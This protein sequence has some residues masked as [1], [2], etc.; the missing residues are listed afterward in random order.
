MKP[1]TFLGSRLATGALVVATLA[2]SGCSDNACKKGASPTGGLCLP[3][4]PDVAC[5]D[6]VCTRYVWPDGSWNKS[7]QC[8]TYK[9]CAADC[10]NADYNLAEALYFLMV[11]I[12]GTNILPNPANNASG[13]GSCK[14]SGQVAVN[15]SNGCY[16]STG[17]CIEDLNYSFT[18]C[19][20]TLG[21][22]KAHLTLSSGSLHRVG[23]Y[24]K[25]STTRGYQITG[26]I[27]YSGTLSVG[28]NVL[29]ATDETLT[30]A[31]NCAVDVTMMT[32]STWAITG[33]L[34][35]RAINTPI[36]APQ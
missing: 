6:H 29:E 31:T 25:T 9:T 33:T 21:L 3:T 26:T 19:V 22:P 34:C 24:P 5:G 23:S 27:A 2:V 20:A 13:S 1:V 16:S 18:N 4:C 35:G 14:D 17:I 11:T 15:G 10:S 7:L 28:Y 36:Y 12:D 8:E 32:G 30:P